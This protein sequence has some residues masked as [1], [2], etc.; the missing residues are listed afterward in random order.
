VAT[1]RALRAR[2]VVFS[3]CGLSFGRMVR[4]L[5]ERGGQ[6]QETVRG[7]LTAGLVPGAVVV[8]AGVVAL[9]RAQE[10]GFSYIAVG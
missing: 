8:T 5:A 3:V 1:L 9:N 6:G 7:A 4:E 10:R 2:G